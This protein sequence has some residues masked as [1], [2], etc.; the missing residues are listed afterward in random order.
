MKYKPDLVSTYLERQGG[1]YPHRPP[2]SYL[3][4]WDHKEL[5]H[6][7]AADIH[8]IFHHTHTSLQ[9]PITQ[10]QMRTC[11]LACMRQSAAHA[12]CHLKI[13]VACSALFQLCSQEEHQL[14]Q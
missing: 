9:F 7:R 1:T 5:C 14:C 6:S 3:Q 12:Y 11:H 8:H 13:Q 2:F 10:D 4:C